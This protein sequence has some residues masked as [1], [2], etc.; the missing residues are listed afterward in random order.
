M[1]IAKSRGNFSMEPLV[2]PG[3]KTKQDIHDF[4][5]QKKEMFLVEL[6]Q[7]VIKDKIEELDFKNKRKAKALKDS[8]LQ[9]QNDDVKLL[10]FIEK[11]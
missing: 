10:K 5:N 1:N 4:I 6:S 3:G 9:L 11:D 8:E 7:N 2:L